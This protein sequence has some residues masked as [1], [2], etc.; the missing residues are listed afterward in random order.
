MAVAPRH[1][2]GRTTAM[3]CGGALPLPTRDGVGPS[4]VALPVGPWPTI[5]E[6]LVARFPSI[7]EAVWHQ[8]I[9]AHEVVDEHG[10]HV[11][12]QR[13]HRAG[14]RVYYYRSLTAERPVPFEARVVFQDDHILV[15]DKPH[16][17]PVTPSGAHLQ[18]TLL[19]R[20]KRSSGIDTLAPVHRIDRETAG[21]VMFTVNPAVRGAYQRLF[22]E[23]VVDKRY[24]CTAP[25]RDDLVLPCTYR[26]RLV[27]DPEHFMR[28][29]E[30]PGNANTETRFS[31][32]E[33]QGGVARYALHP[34]SGHRHQ[35]RAHCAASGIPIVGDRIYPELLPMGTDDHRRPLQLLARTLRFVDPIDGRV[36]E[37]ESRLTLQ[38]LSD[39]Q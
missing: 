26:S 2:A 14:L 10:T 13:P 9:A 38:P 5:A 17:L 28:V 15:A 24:E 18:E 12:L 39:H 22:A 25:W 11:T 21:L 3:T 29:R 27:D 16:F 33:R 20:L 1:S 30:V 36:R 4:C 31:L 34:T 23:R 35:L 32:I 6:C 7:G 19:V 8:R 37:F